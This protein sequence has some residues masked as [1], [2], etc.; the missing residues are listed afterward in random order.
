MNMTADRWQKIEQVYHAALEREESR[1]AAYV[2]QACAC[3]EALQP[4][5]PC[6]P[7]RV[8]EGNCFT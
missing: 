8:V 7:V 6:P 3:D 2:Q 1:R 5:A 4:E